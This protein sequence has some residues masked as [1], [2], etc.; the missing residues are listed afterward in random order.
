[1]PEFR[2]SLDGGITWTYE[3]Q[4]LPYDLPVTAGQY[5]LVQGVGDAVLAGDYIGPPVLP[6][7]PGLAPLAAIEP[8]GWSATYPNPPAGF[9]PATAPEVVQVMRAGYDATATATTFVE[10][11]P[12]TARLRLPYPD[13][14]TLSADRVALAEPVFVQDVIAGVTNTSTL[15]DPAPVAMFT[16]PDRHMVGD[17]LEVAVCAFHGL[18]RNGES[19]AAVVFTASDGTQS[20]TASASAMTVSTYGAGDAG[21]AVLEYRATLDLSGL[22]DDTAITVNARCYPFVGLAYADSERN[23]GNSFSEGRNKSWRPQVYYRKTTHQVI[24]AYVD[25]VL[26]DDGSAVVDRDPA[27]ARAAPFATI[28][29]AV[30]AIETR[31]GTSV[32]GHEIR[33]MAGTHAQWGGSPNSAS[34]GR[35][36]LKITRDPNTSRDAVIL[37]STPDSNSLRLRAVWFEGITLQRTGSNSFNLPGGSPDETH[38]GYAIKIVQGCVVDN[39]GYTGS[40]DFFSTGFNEYW[41]QN[42]MRNV[43]RL[44][45]NQ[46]A[47]HQWTCRGND[48][49]DVPEG[50]DLSDTIG[51]RFRDMDQNLAVVADANNIDGFIC[52]FNRFERVKGVIL[53]S[54]NVTVSYGSAVVQNLI[55]VTEV[56][57]RAIQWSAD[58]SGGSAH[59]N[60]IVLHN[61]VAAQ[62]SQGRVNLFYDETAAGKPLSN[63]YVRGNNFGQL[64]SKTDVFSEYTAAVGNWQVIYGAGSSGNVTENNLVY[65]QEFAGLHSDIAA[66]GADSGQEDLDF[67]DYQALRYDGTSYT[68]GAG[69]GDYRLRPTSRGYRLSP[70]YL[71]FDLD[72]AVRSATTDAGCFQAN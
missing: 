21:G 64:N 72:G 22:A 18:P 19:C 27:A 46:R 37:R 13:Q 66:G 45:F 56:G 58:G 65:N 4:P 31:D 16:R 10:D 34:P 41:L 33:L 35:A 49:L 69:G 38:P 60:Q 39:A 59:N 29:A 52:A 26:G 48:F 54:D 25:P 23:A 68:A 3:D 67:V 36:V 71:P 30:N 2:W 8:T 5:P 61:T 40:N 1:M 6:S 11:I 15:P 28:S 7:N 43:G 14:A 47:V 70:R 20:V 50:I 44:F 12:V 53:R 32:D 63:L 57:D 9:A 62:G 55:E 24:F 17:S 51:N 42:E